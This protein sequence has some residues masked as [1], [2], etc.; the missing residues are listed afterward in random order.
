VNSQ[1]QGSAPSGVPRSQRKPL[2]PA[3]EKRTARRRLVPPLIRR[4]D[5]HSEARVPETSDHVVSRQH[6][7]DPVTDRPYLLLG[8]KVGEHGSATH[9]GSEPSSGK[10][11]RS[12]VAWPGKTVAGNLVGGFR[13]S[14]EAV[15]GG[16][17]EQRGQGSS[18]RKG[19][20]CHKAVAVSIARSGGTRTTTWRRLALI[21][22]RGRA[23][24]PDRHG[25]R[26]ARRRSQ[27]NPLSVLERKKDR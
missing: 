10:R 27:R 15:V 14:P 25:A 5:P 22:H 7:G 26:D 24:E 4:P 17:T 12:A 18:P 3:G 23:A 21:C 19:P 13:L 2:R 9:R 6:G 8:L 16:R 20:S 1:L 11:F